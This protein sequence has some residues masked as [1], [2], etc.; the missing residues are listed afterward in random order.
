MGNQGDLS[1]NPVSVPQD[2]ARNVALGIFYIIASALC[3]GTMPIFGRIAQ[4]AGVPIPSLLVLRF[5]IGAACLWMIMAYRGEACQTGEWLLLLVAIGS[6]GLAGENFC[7]FNALT[8]ASI[9][10]VTLLFYLY[11]AMVAVLARVVFRHPLTGLKVTAVVLSLAGSALTIGKAGDGK[12][13]GIAL[14]IAS[15][16]I[17]SAWILAGSRLPTSVSPLAAT[18][19][20][21]TG[22]AAVYGCLA[23]LKGFLLPRNLAGWTG[24][25]GW[26]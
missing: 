11:P 21:T 8:L 10:L 18:A 25:W 23:V 20:I 17:Y 19:V 2:G 16:V 15:A 3:F 12:P 5:T 6:L 9:G 13:L 7:Y 22:A 4:G 1:L 24:C 26:P 14:A